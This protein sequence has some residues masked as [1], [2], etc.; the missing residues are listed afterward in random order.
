VKSPSTEILSSLVI[1]VTLSLNTPLAA[2]QPHSSKAPTKTDWFPPNPVGFQSS[3]APAT[4]TELQ[5]M[6]LVAP[7]FFEDGQ[8]SS[9]LV[10][11]NSTAMSA[12]ATVTVRSLSGSE[13][14]TVHKK[15]APHEQQEIPL[16]SLLA[17]FAS[18]ITTGSITV[19]QDA[20]LKGMAVAAQLLVT[21]FKASLPSY[22]D[23]ELTMPR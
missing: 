1:I 5:P 4:Q 6:P 12:G 16:L 2:Q 7:I 20:N 18:P 23:E 22:V 17:Q 14:G 13:V 21:K 11:A 15:L 19:T 3:S 10:I 8:T 9:S